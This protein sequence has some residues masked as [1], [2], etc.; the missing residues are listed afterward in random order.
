[1]K[2]IKK[3]IILSVILLIVILGAASAG[4]Y[5]YYQLS[6]I[7][8]VK[9]PKDNKSL[10]ISTEVAKN[11]EEKKIINIAL[12]GDDRRDKDEN[13]RSDSTMILSI[14]QN[15][16][17][18]KVCSI[19]RDMY[20]SVDG[21]GMTKF[22][23]AYSYGGPQLSI[24][25]INENF[26]MDVRDYI[27][28]DF[29]QF[30]Q[31]I[32]S[33]GGVEIPIKSYELPGMKSTGITKA[34]TYN[35]NG[36]QALVY[37]R[38]RYYGNNDYERTERQRLVLSKMFEKVKSMGASSYPSFVAKML[39]L[40]ETSLDKGDIINIGTSMLNS[41]LGSIDQFRIPEDAHKQDVYIDGVY[42]MKW[43]KEPTLEALHNFIYN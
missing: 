25:T 5:V 4:G 18:I 43:D 23:H 21:H 26:N 9:I 22:T 1:M 37:S 34:G 10:G 38:I 11:T 35:L 13:G 41:N 2:F 8:T 7:K 12:F 28:V 33:I 30:Q 24:K 6:K 42:Y 39:P 19:M 16:N 36:A 40:V 27:K 3:H 17:T 14:Y 31:I 20:V 32:D 29:D 15:K